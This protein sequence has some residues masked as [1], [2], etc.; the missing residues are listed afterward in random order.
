MLHN[1]YINKTSLIKDKRSNMI[2]ISKAR[3]PYSVKVLAMLRKYMS[4][5]H[6][7]F[8]MG[9]VPPPTTRCKIESYSV[10]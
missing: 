1:E 6:I 4:G 10:G 7:R 5:V 9:K 8:N 3:L 2:Q